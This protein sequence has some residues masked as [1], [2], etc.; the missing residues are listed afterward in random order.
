MSGVI[1][2]RTQTTYGHLCQHGNKTIGF[3]KLENTSCIAVQ[4]LASY[5]SLC[6]TELV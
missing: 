4:L 6:S 2:L 1:W 3:R 5:E